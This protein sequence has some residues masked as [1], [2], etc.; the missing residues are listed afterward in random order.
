MTNPEVIR[1][2]GARL[3]RIRMR[4]GLSIRDVEKSSLDIGEQYS[5]P[6]F[7]LSRG[8]ITDI[9]MGRYVPGSF[10]MVTLA[11]IYGVT[12]DHIQRFY[13]IH[14][15]DISEERPVFLPPRT[16]II[17]ADEDVPKEERPEA[18]AR[19]QAASAKTT[20]FSALMEVL[21]DNPVPLLRHANLRKFVYGCIGTSDY[22]LSPQIAPGS[23][24]QIDPRQTRVR[25]EPSRLDAG[26]SEWARPIY[27]LDIRTGYACGWCELK[28]GILTL[29]PHPNSGVKTRTFRYPQEVDVVGRVV[30]VFMSITGHFTAVDDRAQRNDPKR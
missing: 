19:Q 11:E 9:E 8:W 18:E 7:C 23:F 12:I 13:G 15:R 14:H 10:K 20:L 3:R 28:D 26:R 21:G 4:L 22:T 27:F 16:H 1:E 5:N 2:A 29:I 17:S 30:S 25:S 24:V 6:E